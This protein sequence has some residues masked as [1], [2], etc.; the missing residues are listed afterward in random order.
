[1]DARCSQDR[2]ETTSVVRGL[3]LKAHGAAIV[4]CMSNRLSPASQRESRAFLVMELLEGGTLRDEL[5]RVGRL[6]PSRI[7]QV[8]RGVCAAVDAAHQRALIHRDLKPENIFISNSA[9][10]RTGETIKVLDFGLAKFLPEDSDSS[11]TLVTAQTQSGALI[12]TSAYMSPEQ[13]LGERLDVRWDLWALAVIAYETL[14]GAP[15]FSAA[16]G[17][18]WRRAVLSGNFTP[19]TKHFDDSP[20]TWQSFFERS[21]ATDVARRPRSAAE[22]LRQV[23]QT[24]GA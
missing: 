12:G 6:E 14:T 11:P 8:F 4:C 1:M 7:L 20:E 2:P 13:L 17:P 23:E 5:H 3:P 18:E 16:P 10:D 15:P 22:F 21:F 9:A 19:L 24:F